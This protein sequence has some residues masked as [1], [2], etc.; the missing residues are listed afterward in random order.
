M[1]ATDDE[2]LHTIDSLGRYVYETNEK[3]KHKKQEIKCFNITKKYKK[4]LAMIMYDEFIRENIKHY[5]SNWP[6]ILDQPYRILI[7]GGSG[8]GRAN[9]LLILARKQ[10]DDDNYDYSIS[11]KIYFCVK[12]PNEAKC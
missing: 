10:N 7:I 11:N 9:A 5:N 8:Y 1:S 12:D 3:I 4:L 6:R 2:R